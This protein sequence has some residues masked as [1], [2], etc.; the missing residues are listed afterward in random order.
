MKF[1]VPVVRLFSLALLLAGVTL[2]AACGSDK[3]KSGDKSEEDPSRGLTAFSDALVFQD[4]QLSS[5]VALI[6]DGKSE[7]S[8]SIFTQR[9]SMPSFPSATSDGRWLTWFD[10]IETGEERGRYDAIIADISGVE[11]A[12]WTL[13]ATPITPLGIS[14]AAER[15][16]AVL[17]DAGIEV[18]AAQPYFLTLF[19]MSGDPLE[20]VALP[21]LDGHQWRADSIP[22]VAVQWLSEAVILLGWG[23]TLYQ[24]DISRASA[25][26]WDILHEFDGLIRGMDLSPDKDQLILGMETSTEGTEIVNLHLG[27]LGAMRL[28][29]SSEEL[30]SPVWSTDGAQIAFLAER[31]ISDCRIR[32]DGFLKCADLC[33]DVI[34]MPAMAEELPLSI[35][36][37]NLQAPAYKPQQATTFAKKDLCS[38]SSIQWIEQTRQNESTGSALNQ[39]LFNGGLSGRV[40]I[41]RALGSTFI[42]SVELETGRESANLID[43]GDDSEQAVF[44]H[45]DASGRWVVA[46][47]SPREQFGS[48]EEDAE[49]TSDLEFETITVNDETGQLVSRFDYPADYRLQMPKISPDGMLIAVSDPRAV[50]GN[51]EVGVL[52]VGIAGE[53]VIE[54]SLLTPEG[55]GWDSYGWFSDGHLLLHKSRQVYRYNTQ[56]GMNT[57]VATFPQQVS[58]VIP[59]PDGSK[60]VFAM[61]GHLWISQRNGSELR[62]LTDSDWFE[63]S[64]QWSPDGTAITFQ[65]G[66]YVMAVAADAERAYVGTGMNSNEAV[67]RLQSYRLGDDELRSI[68]TTDPFFW[69][70]N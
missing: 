44:S 31:S 17:A 35:S 66:G 50:V 61:S 3:K 19:S 1:E 24:L 42:R 53:P 70:A 36:N 28:T 57:L 62:Q 8:R 55:V 67:V 29:Q 69:C 33:S 12:R 6:F 21:Q 38:T 2:V 48:S 54:R 16:A 22:S 9:Q 27:T 32:E 7:R 26:T 45:C 5:Q 56:T 20:R 59:S 30:F 58:D 52:L 64:P 15:I 11:E 39:N 51:F 40:L 43:A 37:Q 60:L 4:A 25:P 65:H 23:K 41:N 47:W 13:G 63:D 14:P 68:Q 49:D 18:G 34:V 46:E 10:W